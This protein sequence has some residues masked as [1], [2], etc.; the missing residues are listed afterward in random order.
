M[1]TTFVELVIR[2]P[3]L[4]V[5]QQIHSLPRLHVILSA[6]KDPPLR[7]RQRQA[8]SSASPHNDNYVCGT[9]HT[10]ADGPRAP[11][12]PLVTKAPCHPERSEGSASP[13][14]PTTSGFFGFASQ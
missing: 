6:A 8:D 12:N 1:T 3:T 4:H 7:R 14:S 5:H 10:F 2:L 9:G 11:A 13:P